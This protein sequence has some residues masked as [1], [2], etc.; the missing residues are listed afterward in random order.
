MFG[1]LVAV[2]G[3]LLFGD[4]TLKDGSE[5]TGAQMS[6][7]DTLLK[8]IAYQKQHPQ[9]S[10]D[11]I[12][13]GIGISSR[14]VRRCKKEVNLL[15]H[16]LTGPTL[17]SGQIQ[18][19]LS[20]LNRQEPDQ[21]EIAQHL[22]RQIGVSYTGSLRIKHPDEHAPLSWLEIGE[23]T[24]IEL[25]SLDRPDPIL[26]SWLQFLC[27][28]PLLISYQNGEIEER[29]AISCEAVEGKFAVAADLEKGPPLERWEADY[30]RRGH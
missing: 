16:Q 27:Y 25:G 9:A 19:L 24:D 29:L 20:L 15:R 13:E 11:K 14:H 1:S 10:D 26:F 18:L 4:S 28:D 23:L 17:Q 21:Q 7:V 8:L 22:Q 12:A 30:S 2:S 5:L 6:K 3:T